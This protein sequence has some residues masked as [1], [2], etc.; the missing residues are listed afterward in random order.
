MSEKVSWKDIHKQEIVSFVRNFYQTSWNWRNQEYHTK[1]DKW[2]R[3]FRNIYDPTAK[4]K[5]EDWQSVLFSPA[6]STN[7]E[8]IASSLTKIASGK[9][10]PIALEP[11]EMG[12]ELQADLNTDLLDYYREKGDYE[13]GRYRATKESCIFGSG[14]MKVFWEKKV[15]KRRVVSDAYESLVTAMSNMRLPKKTGRKSEWKDVVVKDGIRYQ[16][17]HIRDIFPEPNTLDWKRLI[18]RDKLTYNEIKIMGD[19]GYFDKDSVKALMDVREP[20]NFEIEIRPV[21]GDEGKTDPPLVVA[22]YDKRHTIW[23][24]NGP[25]PR[26]WIDLGMSE[27]TDEQREKANEIVSGVILIGSAD[28]YLASGEA[29]TY[30][31][32]HGVVKMDYIPDGTY[33]IGVAQLM[34]GLQDEL[35]EMTNQRI[36]NVVFLMNKMIVV[37][38]KYI[39]DPKEWRSKP[40][41]LMRLK[42]S[43]IDDV[44]KVFAEL[45]ISDVPMS[46]YRE[47]VEIERRIQETTAANRVTTGTAGLVNDANQTLGGMEMLKQAAFDRFLIYAFLQG[48]MFD[49]K[50][51]QKTAEYVYLNANDEAVRKI[52]GMIPIEKLPGQWVPRWECWERKSPEDLNVCYDFVPVDVFSMENRF[53]K[54]QALSSVAQLTASLL[55]GWDPKPVLERLY[56]MLDMSSD[57]ISEILSALPQDGPIQTPMAQGQGV[58]SVSRPTKQTVGEAPPIPTQQNGVNPLG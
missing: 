6:T 49:I 8:V 48:K 35:N 57:E 43:E 37:L 17:V 26:K 21:K 15:E 16:H 51:A 55:P 58:P 36:D 24:Y 56:K 18:H 29:Q 12:D 33:G 3:N 23:E 20:D 50:I 52:L 46:S 25:I 10:R 2:E 28:Y 31:G 53:Q 27:D 9:K 34:E 47:T 54:S 14:F 30:D 39:V 13:I 41:A 40:G 44:K 1:W 32:E 45:N 22:D 38:E 7:V 4:S 42:G 11:R 5:K 19:K